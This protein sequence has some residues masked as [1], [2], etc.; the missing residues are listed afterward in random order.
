MHHHEADTACCS[1]ASAGVT[2]PRAPGGQG[3][4]EGCSGKSSPL[5]TQGPPD[6]TRSPELATASS[7]PERASGETDPGPTTVSARQGPALDLE[8]FVM[9]PFSRGTRLA[10]LLMLTILLALA[11][12]SPAFADADDDQ[13]CEG[14]D[15]GKIDTVGDPDTVEFDA[16]EGKLIS[17]YCVKAGSANQEDGGPVFVS[18]DPPAASVTIAHPSGKA[19]SHYAVQYTDDTPP[20]V[21]EFDEN[22]PAD[23]PACVEDE[24]EV[25]EFDENLPADD[26]AC[27]EDEV[28]V[29]D[30]DET[31]PADDPACVEDEVEVCDFDENLAADDPACEV[32]VEDVVIEQEDDEDA[33]EAE[34]E[35]QVETAVLGVTVARTLPATGSSLLLLTL[36]GL[37]ALGTGGT[38]LLRGKR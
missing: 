11:A 22:L 19:V 13:V 18:V 31:L 27:V 32:E 12:V 29:C 34:V 4:T 7:G 3:R 35:E 33:D 1:A 26:P 28:E 6:R 8:G 21:C 10:P 2:L 24:V 17:G 5:G 9:R 15:S 30:F 25:C 36:A 37:T 14:F 38:L 23:D 16:P 20:E